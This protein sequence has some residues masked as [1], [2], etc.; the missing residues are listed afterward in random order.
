MT[1]L[2]PQPA[3]AGQPTGAAGPD[4]PPWLLRSA[5]PFRS[6]F[7]DIDGT[8]V[9]YVDE[10]SGPALLLVSVGL[11]AFMFRDVILRLR[12]QFR[13]VTLDFPG[14]GLSPV[15]PGHDHSVRANA[16]ILERF[17]DVLDLQDIVLTVHDVGGPVGFLVAIKRPQQL[18]GLVISNTFGWPLAG[19]PEVRRMLKLVGSPLFRGV[20]DVT[21]VF[22]RFTATSYGVG[23]KMSGPDRACF[24]G[25]WRTRGTRRAS[26]RILAGVGQIDPMMAEISK[27]L[28]PSLAGV[29]VLTLFGLKNDPYDWQN[30]FQ[31]IFPHAT[32]DGI[33]GAH[34]FPF[35][36]DP[37]AYSAAVCAWWA[38]TALPATDQTTQPARSNH[39]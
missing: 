21:N 31:Q 30:R 18:R 5:F 4:R 9:H 28:G 25:P 3:G 11:W 17:I 37:D 29:P 38:T 7:V 32:A 8:P 12:R 34:H 19:Y 14:C 33:P 2:T 22:A 26:S 20:N 13:C 39:T 24:L 10:G 15:P 23:R 27:S 16:R 1:A 6:R 36:D 35:C